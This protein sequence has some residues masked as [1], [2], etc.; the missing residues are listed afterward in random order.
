MLTS[1]NGKSYIGQTSG[2]IEVRFRDHKKS[3]SE[4]V[5]IRNAIKKHGWKNMKKNWYECLDEDLNFTEELMISLMGTLAPNGYNLREG[6][7]SHGKMS[8]VTK[9]RMREAQRGEKNGFYG[10][11]HTEKAKQPNK[12]NAK[13]IKV[14]KALGMERPKP[15]NINRRIEKHN[16][17]KL[18]LRKLSKR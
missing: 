3:S 5:A 2:T 14:R 1:P 12:K 17:E 15:M 7:G 6:G 13:P 18:T 4:C 16:S 11:T 10:K 9:K 8:E